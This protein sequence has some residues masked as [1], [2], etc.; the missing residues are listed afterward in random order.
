[1]AA[2]VAAVYIRPSGAG[3][4]VVMGIASVFLPGRH[5]F[6][7]H[8]R[9]PLPVGL[10]TLLLVLAALTPWAV[11][12]RMVLGEWVWT[13]TN[14]GITL[15]DGWQVDNTTGGSDQ[16]FVSRMP[17]LGLMNEVERDSYL[18]RK[19]L[20]SIREWP[21]R[22]V[23]LALKKA[24]RTWSPVPLSQEGQ[25]AYVLAGLL[26]SVPLFV[27]ALAGLSLS[28]LRSSVKAFLL[29]PAMY[30]TVLHMLS[31]GSIRYRLPADPALAILAASGIVALTS[32]FV[33]WWQQSST[34]DDESPEARRRGRGF[35]VI[36]PEND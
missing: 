29:A 16:S 11:R 5:P 9:W 31:V 26:Y 10:T 32:G 1:M 15:Y 19:A 6:A 33:S 7:L 28:D 2:L 18:K 3:L 12:N 24:G 8:S 14:N 4:A 17:Q 23:L 22:S 35:E 30:L 36:Q 34:A 27:L 25:R 20:Q 21:A 13:T